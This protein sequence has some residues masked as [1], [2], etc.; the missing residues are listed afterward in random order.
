MHA[1]QINL[2]HDSPTVASAPPELTTVSGLSE[3]CFG[4]NVRLVVAEVGAHNKHQCKQALCVY[5]T[6]TIT[7]RTTCK[8]WPYIFTL[9]NDVSEECVVE[10]FFRLCL[11]QV[12]AMT[13]TTFHR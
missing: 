2:K 1:L 3:C 8:Q 4:W 10:C 7:K 9:H 13:S 6:T 11:P 12:V 5:K